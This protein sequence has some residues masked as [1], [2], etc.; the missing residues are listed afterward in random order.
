MHYVWAAIV[1][2]VLSFGPPQM[3]DYEGQNAFG[4]PFSAGD[5]PFVWSP[6]PA[7]TTLCPWTKGLAPTPVV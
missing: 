1:G 4:G 6:V 5:T 3:R 7:F 2:E